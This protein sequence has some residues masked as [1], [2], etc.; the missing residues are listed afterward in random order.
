MSIRCKM[1][2]CDTRVP[3]WEARDGYC[4]GCYQEYGRLEQSSE[5]SEVD[6]RILIEA[7]FQAELAPPSFL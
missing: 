4:L 7:E 1:P 6:A 2:Y 3:E 5:H